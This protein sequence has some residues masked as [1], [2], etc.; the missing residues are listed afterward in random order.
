MH[1]PSRQVRTT[2]ATLTIFASIFLK[3]RQKHCCKWKTLIFTRCYRL[4]MRRNRS[5]GTKLLFILS[6]IF[7]GY[8]DDFTLNEI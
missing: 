1:A 4:W 2:D 6:F 8:P 3:S 7:K 5:N